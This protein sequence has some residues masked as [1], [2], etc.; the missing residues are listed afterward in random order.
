MS[1]YDKQIT[2]MSFNPKLFATVSVK[3]RNPIDKIDKKSQLSV[4]FYFLL[5]CVYI[6]CIYYLPDVKYLKLVMELFSFCL[7]F[8]LSYIKEFCLYFCKITNIHD[9]F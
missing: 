8:S 7:T 3:F 1:V 6:Y 5:F 4:V 2:V 9:S